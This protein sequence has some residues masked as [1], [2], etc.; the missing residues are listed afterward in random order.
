MWPSYRWWVTII[1]VHGVSANLHPQDGF[2][3]TQEVLRTFEDPELAFRRRGAPFTFDA[4]AFAGF[5]KTLKSTPTTNTDEP[6]T[7]L[8]A[9]SFDHALKDPIPDAIKI[10]SRN[11]LI[12]LE[13]NYTLLDEMPWRQIA[14]CCEEKYAL[15]CLIVTTD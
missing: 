7:E 11:R 14:D 10:S 4:E 5:V 15:K 9:P 3:H 8:S 1:S 2:H 13:G 6:E 12:I